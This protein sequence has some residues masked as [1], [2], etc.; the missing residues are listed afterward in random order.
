MAISLKTAGAW[1]ETNTDIVHSGIFDTAVAGDRIFIWAAWK[2]FS[3]TASITAAT[4]TWTEVG[5]AFADGSVGN[6]NGTGSV[7]V[8]CWYIDYVGNETLPTIDF[9]SSPNQGASLYQV[10]QKAST[11]V[12]AP[13]TTVTAAWPATS[14]T[15]TVSASSATGVFAGSVVMAQIALRDDSAT[16]TRG[17]TTGIDVAS[18]V[19]WNGNYVESPAT[20]GNYTGGSDGAYDLGHR[21]VTS[22]SSSTV[23]LR[24]TATISATETGSVRWVIQRLFTGGFAQAR[25]LIQNTVTTKQYAQGQAFIGYRTANANFNNGSASNGW[26][27]SNDAGP[28]VINA[29]T[30]SEFSSDGA[31]G[32]HTKPTVSISHHI[33]LPQT[34]IQDVETLVAVKADKLAVGG[35]Q[36][37]F[38]TIRI[39]DSS[40]RLQMQW[41]ANTSN[42]IT[43]SI[44]KVVGGATSDI[45]SVTVVPRESAAADTFF[46][47]RAQAEGINPTILRFKVWRDGTTEPGG[48]DAISS[49]SDASLQQAGQVGLRTFLGAGTSNTPVVFSFDNFSAGPIVTHTYGYAQA[50]AHIVVTA[51]EGFAQAMSR[52]GPTTYERILRGIGGLASFWTLGEPNNSNG[53]KDY[54]GGING[55]VAAEYSQPSANPQQ[56]EPG[57]RF[58]SNSQYADF[59]DNYDFTGTSSFSVL[60]WYKSTN[61]LSG[62]QLINKRDSGSVGW[63]FDFTASNLVAFRRSG[64]GTNDTTATNDGAWHFAV[65]IY[66]GSNRRLSIDDRYTPTSSDSTSVTDTSGSLRIAINS[67]DTSGTFNGTIGSVAILNAAIS[68]DDVQALYTV[69]KSGAIARPAQAQAQIKQTYNGFGQAQAEILA[70]AALRESFAQAQAQIKQIYQSYAQAQARILRTYNSF[71]QAQALIKQTYQRYAQAQSRIAL[72]L[73]RRNSF[74]GGSNGVDITPANS[75]GLSGNAFDNSAPNG[76]TIKYDSTV[77]AHGSVSSKFDLDGTTNPTQLDWIIGPVDELWIRFYLRVSALPSASTSIGLVETNRGSTEKSLFL[78]SA[79]VLRTYDGENGSVSIST[80]SWVRIEVYFRESTDTQIIRLYLSPESLVPDETIEIS[81]GV[82]PSNNLINRVSFGDSE[83]AG[84]DLNVWMDDIKVSTEGWIGP[85]VLSSQGQ[86]QAR[87][88]QTYTGLAQAQALIKSTVSGLAQAQAQIY[89]PIGLRPVQDIT[90]NTGIVGVVV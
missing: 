78:W 19:T 56:L 1:V 46:W 75:G 29:G 71:A 63:R 33:L 18:G 47:M 74:E 41:Q 84:Q 65:G 44:Q 58:T 72:P 13:P 37:A 59:G 54:Y 64:S 40:N 2:D 51:I 23:T 22:S 67:Y 83:G 52:I 10:W 38:E 17:A 73:P 42:Q 43:V 35:T 69:A 66:N 32:K 45:V 3:I 4:G 14:T 55:V 88:I 87:I 39:I 57:M 60:V 16:F 34:S 90:T 62:S 80:N 12:W 89:T 77:S 36:N 79:G 48:W 86:A 76:G 9:S 5:T 85:L 81:S 26:V 53:V 8:A 68:L 11:D 24:V 15:Q 28:W 30:A 49:V 50:R 6:G 70:G 21:F 25:A 7:K 61:T 31:V 27:D 20:H 82:D